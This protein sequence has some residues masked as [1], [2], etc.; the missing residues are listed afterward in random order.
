MENFNYSP[1]PANA[2]FDRELEELL[3]RCVE[4]QERSKQ[5]EIESKALHNHLTKL[6]K[7]INQLAANLK[8][9]RLSTHE[10]E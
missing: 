8:E 4:L 1:K 3:E 10:I 6:G 7:D 9:Q 5:L 2:F